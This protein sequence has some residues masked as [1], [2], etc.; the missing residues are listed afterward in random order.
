MAFYNKSIVGYSLNP[1]SSIDRDMCRVLMNLNRSSF[2]RWGIEIYR[3]H[4]SW[5]VL[6]QSSCLQCNHL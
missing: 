3:L 4:F 2:C 6:K 5:V 1:V